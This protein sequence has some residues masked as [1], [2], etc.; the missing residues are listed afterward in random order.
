MRHVESRLVLWHLGSSAGWLHTADSSLLRRL[1][2]LRPRR[3]CAWSLPGAC[4]GNRPTS[5]CH[6]RCFRCSKCYLACPV[7]PSRVPYP[8]MPA[9]RTHWPHLRSQAPEDAGQTQKDRPVKRPLDARFCTWFLT[10]CRSWLWAGQPNHV[11]R[12]TAAAGDLGCSEQGELFKKALT[13]VP[14]SLRESFYSAY[15]AAFDGLS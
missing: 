8:N 5:S 11:E 10:C 13:Y 9:R 7:S 3:H 4:T 6:A 2:S 15:N 1:L 12:E 14:A